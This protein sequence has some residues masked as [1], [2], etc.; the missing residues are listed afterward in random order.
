MSAE[1]AV[2]LAQTGIA[3]QH[4]FHVGMMGIRILLIDVFPP[5]LVYLY[6]IIPKYTPDQPQVK[7]S[8][9]LSLFFS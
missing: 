7:L 4:L 8:F 2:R 3:F 1:A 6:T 9:P 5:R